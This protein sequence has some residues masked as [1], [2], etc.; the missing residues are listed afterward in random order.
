MEY[1]IKVNVDQAR[2]IARALDLFSRIGIG[3]IE[4]VVEEAHKMSHAKIEAPYAEIEEIV[5]K[6]K[7]ALFGM[8][9][10]ASHSICSDKVDVAYREAYDILQVIRHRLAWDKN[11]NGNKMSIDFD[12]PTKWVSDYPPVE[13]NRVSHLTDHLEPNRE[14]LL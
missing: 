11:P 9:I 13:I 5:D 2:I 10:N 6:L 3:Q 7:L 12:K 8:P 4:M 1:T 14:E